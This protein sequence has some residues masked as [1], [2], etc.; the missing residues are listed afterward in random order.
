MMYNQHAPGRRRQAGAQTPA[1]DKQFS[2]R[3]GV[4]SGFGFGFQVS[5]FSL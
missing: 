5:G 1:A 4:V 2:G 3:D